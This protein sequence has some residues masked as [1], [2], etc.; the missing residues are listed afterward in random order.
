M[1]AGEDLGYADVGRPLVFEVL[2]LVIVVFGG[3]LT[4]EE[5]KL[6]HPIKI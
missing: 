1:V 3:G 5:F 2:G 6:V 4:G